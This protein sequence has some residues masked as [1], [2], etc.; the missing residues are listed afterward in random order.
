VPGPAPVTTALTC[1]CLDSLCWMLQDA[2]EYRIT[3]KLHC[4]VSGTARIPPRSICRLVDA[5]T[6]FNTSWC[7]PSALTDSQHPQAT[8]LDVIGTPV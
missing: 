6:G 1:K 8:S 4:I 7:V 3:A 2:A 5:Q